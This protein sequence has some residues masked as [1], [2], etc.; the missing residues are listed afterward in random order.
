MILFI[1]A[2][3]SPFD[4]QTQIIGGGCH[5][6]KIKRTRRRLSFGMPDFFRA[7]LK[8]MDDLDRTAD[9]GSAG[10]GFRRRFIS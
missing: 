2:L 6:G 3:W 4:P 8:Q 5:E 10:A 7:E 1:K 9:F